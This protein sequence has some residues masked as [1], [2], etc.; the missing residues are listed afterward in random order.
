MA[1]EVK[2]DTVMVPVRK[3]KVEMTWDDVLTPLIHAT[4]AQAS[5]AEGEAQHPELSR[6]VEKLRELAGQLKDTVNEINRLN[7]TLLSPG[8]KIR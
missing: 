2:P 8:N 3:Y 1:L 6:H 4:A 7:P 5:L